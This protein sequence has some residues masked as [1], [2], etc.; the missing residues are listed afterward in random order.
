MGVKIHFETLASGMR[1]KLDTRYR[2]N[3]YTHKLRKFY[4]NGL[5]TGVLEDAIGKN[6]PVLAGRNK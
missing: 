3:N 6:R 2:D 1:A 5:S 4:G